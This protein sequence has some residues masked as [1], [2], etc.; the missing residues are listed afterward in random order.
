VGDVA[1]KLTEFNATCACGW[2]FRFGS[3][4]WDPCTSEHQ[5]VV[6]GNADEHA[7]RHR[8]WLASFGGR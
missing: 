6:F 7:A 8:T 2:A 5:L 3:D 4:E 1:T